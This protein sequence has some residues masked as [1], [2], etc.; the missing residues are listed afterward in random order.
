VVGKIATE[1]F[2]SLV[3][4]A[5][6]PI[7][8]YLDA[9]D[10]PEPLICLVGIPL[11]ALLDKHGIGHLRMEATEKADAPTRRLPLFARY[12]RPLH[13]DMHKV[14]HVFAVAN[15]APCTKTRSTPA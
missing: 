5:L 11:S 15:A 14:Q 12:V 6:E 9:R 10:S 7:V 1:R 8:D 13:P 3:S 4:V 2:P